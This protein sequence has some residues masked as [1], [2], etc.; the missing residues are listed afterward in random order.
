ML[1]CDYMPKSIHL[2]L[3]LFVTCSFLVC[4]YYSEIEENVSRRLGPHLLGSNLRNLQSSEEISAVTGAKT[5]PKVTPS[6][7]VQ[8]GEDEYQNKTAQLVYNYSANSLN[9]RSSAEIIHLAV[10]LCNVGQK[11]ALKWNFKKMTRS[12][13]HHCSKNIALHFHLVTDPTSWETAKE[14]IHHEAKISKLNVQVG[15]PNLY[16]FYIPVY[17]KLTFFFNLQVSAYFI[18]TF[19]KQFVTTIK[20]LQQ[21]FSARPGT[22]YGQ[23]LFYVSVRLPDLI[24]SDV[25]TLIFLDVDTE[26]RDNIENLNQ[27]FQY[28]DNKQLL[29]LAPELSPVYRHILYVYRNQHK[30]SLLGEP[31]GK[32]FPGYN[33]GVVLMK[34]DRMRQSVIYQSLITNSSL[35]NLTKKYSFKG[36]LGDQDFYSLAAFENPELFYTLPCNWNRQL[37]QWWK[38]KGYDDIFDLFYECKGF[39]SLF[40]GNCNSQIPD[41]T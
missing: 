41:A 20:V 1:L 33:S 23:A 35:S 36:H 17:S 9:D 24:P 38:S 25:K 13:I 34:L 12:L 10:I 15:I 30:T 29:G 21:Y 26:F 37:C 22:Y 19:A 39:I 27:H 5:I 28:F 14:I 7:S 8:H 32:G 2:F 16:L 18:D 40:H 6:A 11:A 4:L 31:K 3:F